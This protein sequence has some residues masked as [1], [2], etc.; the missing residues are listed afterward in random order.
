MESEDKNSGKDTNCKLVQA[1]KPNKFTKYVRFG[2]QSYPFFRIY[3]Q[4][5]RF[6]TFCETECFYLFCVNVEKFE[7][8]IVGRIINPF[9]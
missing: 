1:E 3:L 5:I 6:M 2:L 9:N 7:N 8:G 4:L